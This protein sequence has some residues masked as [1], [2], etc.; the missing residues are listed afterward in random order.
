M[1]G[2][3]QPPAGLFFN[4]EGDDH[5]QFIKGLQAY[6]E[7]LTMEQGKALRDMDTPSKPE[8]ITRRGVAFDKPAGHWEQRSSEIDL[9]E[10]VEELQ[11]AQEETLMP[12]ITPQILQKRAGFEAF[13]EWFVQ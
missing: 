2:K 10:E 6:V 11:P 13:Q 8:T 12:M 7:Q 1:S 4:E 5:E 9:H 3:K